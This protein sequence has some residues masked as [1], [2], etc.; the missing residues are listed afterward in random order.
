L[1]KNSAKANPPTNALADVIIPG[2]MA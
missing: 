2:C 1:P